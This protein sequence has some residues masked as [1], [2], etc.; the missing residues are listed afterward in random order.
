MVRYG[1]QT[2]MGHIWDTAAKKRPQRP[3][4]DNS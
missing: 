1:L 3:A 2:F 4:L